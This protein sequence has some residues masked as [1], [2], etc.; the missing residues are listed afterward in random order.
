ME[1][2]IKLINRIV[3]EAIKDGA[4]SGGAYH[5]NSKGL[6]DVLENWLSENCLEGYKVD[7]ECVE[8]NGWI[9]SDIM[10][11]VQTK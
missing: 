10:Q 11:I 6:K 4:D 2:Q 5:S 8:D 9:W 1:N 3:F 7:E